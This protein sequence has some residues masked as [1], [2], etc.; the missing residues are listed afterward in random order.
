MFSIQS[1][2]VSQCPAKVFS[3][4]KSLIAPILNL[5]SQHLNAFVYTGL[6]AISGWM[7]GL[8]WIL[9]RKLVLLEHLA[10]LKRR[11][12]AFLG[13]HFFPTSCSLDQ[14]SLIGHSAGKLSQDMVRA[15]PRLP[16]HVIARSSISLSYHHHC[17]IVSL[18]HY[19]QT[20]F[21]ISRMPPPQSSSLWSNT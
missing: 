15:P 6:K 21:V 10:M 4:R 8:D 12:L 1:T 2:P 9:L 20:L 14:S 18:S 19:H 5:K 17:L 13:S 3:E 7:D 16:I 11:E